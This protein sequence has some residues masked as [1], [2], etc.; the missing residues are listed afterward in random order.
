MQCD[1]CG[2]RFHFE[3]EVDASLFITGEMVLGKLPDDH[4][5]C[6]GTVRVLDP[7][8][9]LTAE[10][11]RLGLYDVPTPQSGKDE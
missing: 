7:T 6:G 2:R 4:E 5:S 9:E 8:D 1:K 3:K 10:A 11:Q